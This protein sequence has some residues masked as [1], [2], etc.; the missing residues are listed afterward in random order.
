M[1]DYE[2]NWPEGKREDRD[3]YLRRLKRSAQ[4]IPSLMID[5]AVGHLKARCQRLAD[6]HGAQDRSLDSTA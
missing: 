3:A 4:S 1:R 5:D 6:A 2:K